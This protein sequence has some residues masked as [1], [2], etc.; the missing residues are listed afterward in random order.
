MEVSIK[1]DM[2]AKRVTIILSDVN[3]EKMAL[4]SFWVRLFWNDG[5]TGGNKAFS[6][7]RRHQTRR[8]AGDMASQVSYPIVTRCCLT[9]NNRGAV[10]SPA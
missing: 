5:K 8:F 10:I 9:H 1:S 7:I 4:E 6:Q 2:K 3:F